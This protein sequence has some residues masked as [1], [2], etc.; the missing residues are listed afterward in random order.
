MGSLLSTRNDGVQGNDNG[1]DNS[2][3]I[4]NDT[5]GRAITSSSSQPV[6]ST[7]YD[8][9]PEDFPWVWAIRDTCVLDW[10]N[11]NLTDD[12]IIEQAKRQ[13]DL[14]VHIYDNVYL[15]DAASVSNISKLTGLGIT[16]VLNVAGPM[17]LRRATIRAFE[18]N[19]ITY[20][21]ITAQDEEDYPFLAIHWNEIQ[22]FIHG[23]GT[24]SGSGNCVIHCVAAVNRSVL[25][26][27]ADYM[28]TCQR[29]VLEAVKHVR[30]QRGNVALCNTY[31]QQQLVALARRHDLLGAPPGTPGSVAPDAIVPPPES[32]TT[33]L[34]SSKRFQSLFSDC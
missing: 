25:A 28:V 20:S 11:D 21:R 13:N 22:D 34:K 29:P 12:E 6:P 10:K 1:N 26:V 15:G 7:Y 3:A 30:R 16:R 18:N 24:S 17:A 9:Q 4:R 2:T 33:T 32:K 14:P 19:G 31:F 8:Y 23:G 27:T 5:G